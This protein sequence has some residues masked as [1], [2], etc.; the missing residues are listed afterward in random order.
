M[1][2]SDDQILAQFNLPDT[3]QTRERAATANAALVARLA[4][5]YGG[6]LDRHKRH[7]IYHVNNC[8]RPFSKTQLY[9]KTYLPFVV[10]DDELEVITSA[11]S[12]GCGGCTCGPTHSCFSCHGDAV[13]AVYLLP[14]LGKLTIMCPVDD[15]IYEVKYNAG[16][17]KDADGRYLLPPLLV[18]YAWCSLAEMYNSTC[19]K[20]DDK[21][22]CGKAQVAASLQGQGALTR[23][24]PQ[25]YSPIQS[26]V[27]TADELPA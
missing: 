6:N 11:S 18:D 9:L 5:M 24:L 22:K 7:D 14:D 25:A 16:F 21:C 2:F 3:S 20:D 15:T 10:D 17:E 1:I 23:F 8:R 26:Q 12:C 19:N 13:S 4:S 27:V